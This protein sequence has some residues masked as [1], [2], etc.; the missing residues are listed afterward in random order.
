MTATRRALA[1]AG[2]V[3]LAAAWAVAAHLLWKSSVPA[4]VH[5]PKLDEH[6]YFSASLLRR[7]SSFDAFLRVDAL[8]AAVA[9]VV[10]VAIFARRG[11]SL[12]RHSA[13]GPIGT[14]MLLGM[15]GLG[16]VW[17]VQLPFGLAQLWAERQHDIARQGYLDYAIGNFLGLGG[18]FLFISFGLL[19]VM[20]AA[21]L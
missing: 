5:L 17:L 16:I 8:L 1:L 7:T 15:L 10:T 12:M 18:E 21:R 4:S 20:G 2:L 9:L 14:G 11:T 13:A 3:A 19:V 6:A